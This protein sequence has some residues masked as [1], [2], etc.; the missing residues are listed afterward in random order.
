MMCGNGRR[1]TLPT[2]MLGALVS[3]QYWSQTQVDRQTKKVSLL[4]LSLLLLL[5]LLIFHAEWAV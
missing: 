1:G 3:H 2:L 4:L 5:L